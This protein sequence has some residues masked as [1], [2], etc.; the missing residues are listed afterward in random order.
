MVNKYYMFYKILEILHNETDE[1]HILTMPELIERLEQQTGEKVCSRTVLGYISALKELEFDIS[2][3]NENRK[4]YFLQERSFEEHEIRIL[5]DCIAACHFITKDKTKALLKKLENLG[6]IY[7]R[8]RLKNQ[9]Y[10]DGRSKASNEQ[11]YY[12]IDKINRAIAENKKISF[13]Y[14]HY[15]IDR[16]LLPKLQDGE[17]KVYTVSPVFTVLREECY[18]LVSVCDRYEEPTHYRIDRMRMVNVLEN[19]SRRNLSEIEEFRHGVDPAAYI[20]KSF[21]MYSGRDCRVVIKFKKHLLDKLLDELGDDLD[22]KDNEDGTFTGSFPAK[23]SVGLRR[24]IMQFGSDVQVLEPT[25]LIMD[26]KEE[27][28]VMRGLYS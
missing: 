17:D 27:L 7:T 13:N 2:D 19:E 21:K 28:E 16:L 18:Y 10:I 22:L 11:I 4:G 3:Y 26:I 20:K 14:C 23:Y 25:I 5:R 6:N 24:W 1:E 15:N 12:N 9:P 8:E